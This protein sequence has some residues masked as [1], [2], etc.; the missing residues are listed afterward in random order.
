MDVIAWNTLY[1]EY[2]Y[3]KWMLLH[4]CSALLNGDLGFGNLILGIKGSYHTI[5]LISL[6]F[7]INSACIYV[8]LCLLACNV[9][10][11]VHSL[12]GNYNEV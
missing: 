7:N 9:T 10:L 2:S 12:G 5:T 6:M 11:S 3:T 8:F 1:M 4:A